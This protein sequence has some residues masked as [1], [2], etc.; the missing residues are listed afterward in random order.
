MHH[1]LTVNTRERCLLRCSN[2]FDLDFEHIQGCNQDFYRAREVLM[3]KGT[4]FVGTFR[5]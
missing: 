4:M 2:V 5:K 1:D 3:K